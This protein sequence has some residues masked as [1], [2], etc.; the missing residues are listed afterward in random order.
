MSYPPQ[1][2]HLI[3]EAVS[4]GKTHKEG[5]GK[6][7]AELTENSPQL[8]NEQLRGLQSVEGKSVVST[9]KIKNS[10]LT[11]LTKTILTPF[12]PVDFQPTL[13]DLC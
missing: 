12:C 5:L 8:Q 2:V 13:I 1:P 11:N 9:L 3:L 4:R 6:G 7:H 10:L